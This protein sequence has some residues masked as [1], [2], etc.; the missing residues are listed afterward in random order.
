MHDTQEIDVQ[1]NDIEIKNKRGK[2]QNKRFIAERAKVAHDMA[3]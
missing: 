1:L 3:L 2:D